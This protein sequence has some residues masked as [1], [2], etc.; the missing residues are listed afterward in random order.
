MCTS[1]YLYRHYLCVS[2]VF[3]CHASSTPVCLHVRPD[4]SSY[5]PQKWLINTA[6]TRE[7]QF[8]ARTNT[9]ADMRG[10]EILVHCPQTLHWLL[11]ADKD[12]VVFTFLDTWYTHT[13]KAMSTT[14][15]FR[16]C[17][18]IT[19][20]DQNSGINCAQ[21]RTD[22]D[23]KKW[24]SHSASLQPTAAEPK[25]PGSNLT[26][27]NRENGWSSACKT[28]CRT[29]TEHSWWLQLFMVADVEQI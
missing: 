9:H 17:C 27:K 19:R 23:T 1:L 11:W 22:A 20:L 13:S 3:L 15:K 26:K 8:A 21:T 12:A 18:S 6:R 14:S 24:T 16:F 4:H 7:Q 29:H 2:T 10:A 28:T 25:H 5:C